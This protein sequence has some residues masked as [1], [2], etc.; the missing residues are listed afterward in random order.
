MHP[1]WKCKLVTFSVLDLK[2]L[3]LD[4]LLQHDPASVYFSF[5]FIYVRV[6]E[7]MQF[8]QYTDET[9]IIRNERGPCKNS[10]NDLISKMC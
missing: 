8:P 7:V 2:Y 5:S 10:L 6:G 3:T 1:A 4:T 9:R